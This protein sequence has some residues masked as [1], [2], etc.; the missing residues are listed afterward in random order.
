MTRVHS[1]CVS[2]GN[3][4]AADGAP[5]TLI[6]LNKDHISVGCRVTKALWNP[7]NLDMYLNNYNCIIK[8]FVNRGQLSFN[9][10]MIAS[11]TCS[12]ITTQAC[13]SLEVTNDMVS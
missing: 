11:I 2:V 5:S 1:T 12:Y 8:M 4:C 13:Y 3:S 10:M 6:T 9:Y 7:G